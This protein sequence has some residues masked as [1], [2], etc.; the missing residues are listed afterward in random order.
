M[1]LLATWCVLSLLVPLTV[2][3]WLKDIAFAPSG[4]H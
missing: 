1:T 4:A 2:G 3:R